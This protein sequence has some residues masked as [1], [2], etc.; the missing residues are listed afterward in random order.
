M[1]PQEQATVAEAR[2]ILGRY[3]NTNPVISSSIT[4]TR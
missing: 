2:E 1:T 4:A 3:L